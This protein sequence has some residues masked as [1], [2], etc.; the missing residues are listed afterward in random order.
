MTPSQYDGVELI[1]DL[2]YKACNSV[3]LPCQ[4]ILR[5]RIAKAMPKLRKL[6]FAGDI[7]FSNKQNLTE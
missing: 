4:G 5:H 1:C 2:C 3:L 6:L 7:T